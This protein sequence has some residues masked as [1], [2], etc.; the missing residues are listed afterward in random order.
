M[1][2]KLI[3]GIIIGG[4]V[5]FFAGLG[6]GL[7][8]NQSSNNLGAVLGGV[9]HTVSRFDALGGFS[10]N[11]ISV[12]NGN[13]T[14]TGNI[15]GAL[16][17]TL[18]VATNTVETGQ[19]ICNY[20]TYNIVNTTANITVTFA[21]ATST[22]ALT[23]KTTQSGFQT[24][25]LVADGQSDNDIYINNSTNTVTFASSTGDIMQKST[26]TSFTL[27]AGQSAQVFTFRQNSS[28]NNIVVS[29]FQ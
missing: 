25:C 17:A 1:N 24:G 20:D 11:D 26:S 16:S 22:N 10:V 14:I 4:A 19:T 2:K 23:P 3:A 13:G 12:V 8:S 27:A 28:T 15:G 9:T 6:I 7:E 18:Q 5:V 21:P 29:T